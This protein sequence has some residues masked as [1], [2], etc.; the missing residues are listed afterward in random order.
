M[1]SG[2]TVLC[3]ACFK[4]IDGIYGT[5]K[6]K[7]Q[8]LSLRGTLNLKTYDPEGV[9]HYVYAILGEEQAKITWLNFCDGKCIDQYMSVKIFLKTQYHESRSL[10]PVNY[11]DPDTLPPQKPIVKL[12]PIIKPKEPIKEEPKKPEEPPHEFFKNFKY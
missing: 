8:Y 1:R 11:I 12:E 5:A 4:P 9:E 2:I 10:P 3:D 6:V 7:K